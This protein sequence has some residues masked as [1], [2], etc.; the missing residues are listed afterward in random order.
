MN[1]KQQIAF[2]KSQLEEAKVLKS[3]ANQIIANATRIESE[4]K[5]ALAML[6]TTPRRTRK[7]D[8]VLPEEAKLKLIGTLTK[9]A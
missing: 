2:H 5:R 7:G 4:A 8:N 9:S 1:R 6:G 3:C